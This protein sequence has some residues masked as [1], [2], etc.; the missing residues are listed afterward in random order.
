MQT[1]SIRTARPADVPALHSAIDTVAREGRWLGAAQAHPVEEMADFI[2]GLLQAGEPTIVAVDPDAPQTI[3]GWCDI[4]HCSP[5]SR[6]HCGRLGM[7]LLPDWRGHGLGRRL[8]QIALD[9]ADALRFSR[10]ELD[11]VTDNTAA[12][13]LYE[14][15]G[16][17]REGVKAGAWRLNDVT[18]D[19]LQMARRNPGLE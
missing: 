7:G 11:V 9:Q 2:R 12:I 6:R 1:I 10:V 5:A 18:R 19:I 14:R 3:V 17:V 13:A 16:F 4:A 15:M 8:L